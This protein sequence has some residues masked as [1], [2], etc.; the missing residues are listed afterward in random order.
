LPRTQGKS[1][2]EREALQ[3]KWARET[4]GTVVKEYDEFTKKTSVR[5]ENM[6]E[7]CEDGRR[8]HVLLASSLESDVAQMGFTS[9]KGSWDYLDCHAVH[10]L[11]DGE[12]VNL[13]AA[14]EADADASSQMVIVKVKVTAANL[15]QIAKATLVKVRVCQTVL[16]FSPEHIETFGEFM[17]EAA[18]PEAPLKAAS[19]IQQPVGAA[20]P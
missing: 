7:R 17:R 5:I 19:A 9:L 3:R 12:P 18:M 6:S 15:A 16:T 4:A 8:L 10:L 2:E 11:A 13:P 1:K 14:A 20:A